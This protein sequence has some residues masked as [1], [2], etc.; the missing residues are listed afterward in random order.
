MVSVSL[1]GYALTIHEWDVYCTPQLVLN[2]V[3][4]NVGRQ[5]EADAWDNIVGGIITSTA[6]SFTWVVLANAGRH[7]KGHPHGQ[8]NSFVDHIKAFSKGGSD[9]PGNLQLLCGTCNTKKGAK[10]QGQFEKKLNQ[11]KGKSTTAKKTSTATKAAAKSST[12]KIGTKS[13]AKKKPAQARRSKDPFA[14]LFSF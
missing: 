1:V 11:E 6:A 9:K 7:H 10:T 2:L 3:D 5:T 4:D 13:T 12:S 8:Y 14:D